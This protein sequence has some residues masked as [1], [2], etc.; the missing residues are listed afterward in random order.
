M[1]T[2]DCQNSIAPTDEEL[3]SFALDGEALPD[4]ARTHLEQCATCQQRLARYE[5]ASA[6]LISHL[7]RSQ[8][9]TGEQISLY[10]AD[11]LPENERTR[12]ATHVLE[13]PLCAAKSRIPGAS[14]KYQTSSFLYPP[15]LLVILY[16]AFLPR[17]SCATTA[18][19][20]ARR[21]PRNNLA[22]PVQSRICRSFPASIAHEQ[23]RAYAARHPYQHRSR[24]ER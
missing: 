5:Q 14:C 12:I 11:L 8:C 4:A 10:C 17:V 21:R 24:G 22:A 18:I 16:A 23:R 3:L 9:P 20:R 19:R 6:Y 1:M 2:M 7:Y 15:Y 13:C